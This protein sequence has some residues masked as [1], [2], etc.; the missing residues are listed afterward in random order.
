VRFDPQ[1]NMVP[2]DAVAAAARAAAVTTRPRHPD[3]LR[4]L[5]LAAVL[6][7]VGGGALLIYAEMPA[8]EPVS[9]KSSLA[10]QAV[11]SDIESTQAYILQVQQ[12]EEVRQQTAE[13]RAAFD[14][15]R[16]LM[17]VGQP[18]AALPHLKQ[19]VRLDPT[20]ANAR[21]ELGL[22]HVRSGNLEAASAELLELQA[23]NPSLANLLQ[24][25]I[26]R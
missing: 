3:S 20:F 13:S 12:Q 26:P 25:L 4:G 24:N 11:M 10:W 16:S 8:P 14:R 17:A 21:Y 22:A 6:A 15:G 5:V 23:I 7:T 1:T 2:D 9:P 19:S 18:A